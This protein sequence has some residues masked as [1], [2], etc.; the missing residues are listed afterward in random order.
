[1]TYDPSRDLSSAC[2]RCQYWGGLVVQ[3]HSKCTRLSASLQADPATG[4]DFWTAGAGDRLP[5]GWAPV[6]FNLKR[7]DNLWG[8]HQPAP[9]WR[10]PPS[11]AGQRP[12][13]PSEAAAWDR[14]QDRSAWRVTDALLHRARSR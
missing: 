2:W 8:A 4:C 1:M 7:H 10:P 5:P 9:E 11:T 14:E 12:G 6:G 13:I 3:V